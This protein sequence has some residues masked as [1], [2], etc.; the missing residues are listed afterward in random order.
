MKIN[1]I[2]QL[3]LI[4][5]AIICFTFGLI[6]IMG[7]V[8]IDKPFNNSITHINDKIEIFNKYG[9]YAYL[10]NGYYVEK[11]IYDRESHYF[12]SLNHLPIE[13]LKDPA[14][15]ITT[16]V[17]DINIYNKDILLYSF[18]G[19]AHPLFRYHGYTKNSISYFGP[20]NN[21]N[22]TVEFIVP[23]GYPLKIMN[24][25][26]GERT[27]IS[28]YFNSDGLLKI[29][30]TGALFLLS[31]VWFL[32]S[33]FFK[34]KFVR[35]SLL[36]Y[37]LLTFSV[38]ILIASNLRLPFVNM[39][40]YLLRMD[41]SQMVVCILPMLLTFFLYNNYDFEDD[42]TFKRMF[43]LS[44]TP[45]ILY[46]LYELFSLLFEGN[47]VSTYIQLFN[48]AI[49]IILLLFIF[50]TCFLNRSLDKRHRPLLLVAIFLFIISISITIYDLFFAEQNAKS[51]NYV[52]TMLIISMALF[53]YQSLQ[54]YVETLFSSAARKSLLL[55]LYTDPMTKLLNRDAFNTIINS[56]ER[57]K[58]S[59][60]IVVID[61]NGLK[62][63][64]DNFGHEAGDRLIK[65]FAEALQNSTQK[66]SCQIFRLGGDEF[67]ILVETENPDDVKKIIHQL[68]IDFRPEQ[69]PGK[70]FAY[71]FAFCYPNDNLLSRFKEADEKMYYYKQML[72]R[73]E[74]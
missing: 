25:V 2:L 32:T 52:T 17:C 59:Y 36:S 11:T 24:L 22:I 69:I 4:A 42:R 74:R 45:L 12:I 19:T 50:F 39:E 20:N 15:G 60:I 49:I 57:K 3:S 53:T 54:M 68:Q 70:S 6:S 13:N 40:N 9:L 23:A 64:N 28:K 67:A 14:I 7:E 5:I 41:I 72:K 44:V 61:I 16:S 73:E 58:N 63:L 31:V 56:T 21:G 29:Y 26:V 66:H 62:F 8:N 34:K 37:A 38:C 71:G 33:L 48:M 55:K 30:L 51:N 35:I 10:E 46:I 18:S 27:T 47:I 43:Y 65:D 1:R